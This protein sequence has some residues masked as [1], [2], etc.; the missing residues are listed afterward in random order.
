M[1]ALPTS[2]GSETDSTRMGLGIFHTYT[3]FIEEHG[4]PSLVV[5]YI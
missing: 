4:V 3:R 1:T 5:Y 2:D